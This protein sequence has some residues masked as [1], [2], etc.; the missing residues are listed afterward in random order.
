MGPCVPITPHT[1]HSSAIPFLR[2][3]L[4]GLLCKL[5]GTRMFI[6]AL[7]VIA[8]PKIKTPILGRL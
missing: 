8:K 6:T 2:C 5:T 4:N 3:I 1:L 7:F